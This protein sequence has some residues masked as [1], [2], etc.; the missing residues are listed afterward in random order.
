MIAFM[1]KIN[2]I[3]ESAGRE[4]RAS[5]VRFSN[6]IFAQFILS[7]LPP[8]VYGNAFNLKR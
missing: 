3:K 4:G 1:G 5:P 6:V 2:T 7:A 8:A